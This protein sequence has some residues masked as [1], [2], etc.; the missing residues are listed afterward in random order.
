MHRAIHFTNDEYSSFTSELTTLARA[1]R[2][3]ALTQLL[4][5]HSILM[6][7]SLMPFP[8]DHS[9]ILIENHISN[10]CLNLHALLSARMTVFHFITF[11]LAIHT[12]QNKQALML[13]WNSLIIAVEFDRTSN[14]SMAKLFILKL[15]LSY[16]NQNGTEKSAQSFDETADVT[17][18]VKDSSTDK[19]APKETNSYKLIDVFDFKLEYTTLRV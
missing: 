18:Q 16:Q 1:F 4:Y 5:M 9:L 10:C 3:T 2:E 14:K 17:A 6:A 19:Q 8:R 15:L 11:A 13:K 7:C 12:Y